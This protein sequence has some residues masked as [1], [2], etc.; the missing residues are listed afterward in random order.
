MLSPFPPLTMS[1]QRESRENES[2]PHTRAAARTRAALDAEETKT[3]IQRHGHIGILT[4][5]PESKMESVTTLSASFGPPKSPGVRLKGIRSELME[6][7]IAHMIRAKVHAEMN[8]PTPKTDF[9]ST[10]QR[11]FTAQGFVP[12]APEATGAHDYKKDQAVTFWSENYERIQG[13][14]A[15][16]TQKSPFRKWAYFSTPIGDRLDDLE[17]PPDD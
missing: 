7:H 3:Q 17:P 13:V 8:P 1:G 4:M 5:D 15:V 11:D 16:Q 9:S 14:T 10:T 2:P 12:P 6:K